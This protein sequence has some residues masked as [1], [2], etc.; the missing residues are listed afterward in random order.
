[1]DEKNEF[2]D[3]E[4]VDLTEEEYELFHDF[5]EKMKKAENTA[6]LK[7]CYNQ[8][9]IIIDKALERKKQQEQ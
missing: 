1:M 3:M 7:Y 5:K 4:I 9:K 8:M 2:P 6:E